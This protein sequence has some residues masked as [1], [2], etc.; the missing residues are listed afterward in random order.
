MGN[1]RHAIQV[2][3]MKESWT[4]I[5]Y[6][7]IAS[8][9]KSKMK[10]FHRISNIYWIIKWNTFYVTTR[11]PISRLIL[12]KAEKEYKDLAASQGLNSK[13]TITAQKKCL[14][15]DGFLIFPHKSAV[16]CRAYL[17]Y[18]CFHLYNTTNRSN[19]EFR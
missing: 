7:S 3:T 17:F 16:I 18:T 19:R 8:G 11:I 13:A 2:R 4:S 5:V 14:F 1:T 15:S 12:N 6:N 10:I 9:I